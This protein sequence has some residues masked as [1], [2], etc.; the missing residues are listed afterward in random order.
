MDKPLI[1]LS[2]RRVWQNL[3]GVS[4][5]NTANSLSIDS[6]PVLRIPALNS[7]IL[8]MLLSR[9]SGRSTKTS[10]NG[11]IVGRHIIQYTDFVLRKPFRND[12]DSKWN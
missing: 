6:P 12:P 9:E 5:M 4:T 10:Q 8:R 11:F 7:V 2:D 3:H 1:S